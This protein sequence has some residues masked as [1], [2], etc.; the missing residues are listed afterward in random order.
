MSPSPL[1]S[2]FFLLELGYSVGVEDEKMIDIVT[3]KGRYLKNLR[4]I[5]TPEET[6]LVYM[7]D[8]V[9]RVLHKRQSEEKA[10]FVLMGHNECERGVYETFV[11]G[12]IQVEDIA[13]EGTTPLWTNSLWSKIFDEIKRSYEES[14]IVGWAI[15]NM[16]TPVRVTPKLEELHREHF[17]G[18]RELFVMMNPLMEEESVFTYQNG[19]LVKKA[20][21]FIYYDQ[22]V[23]RQAPTIEAKKEPTVEVETVENI[24]RPV[25]QYRQFLLEK[26]TS[27]EKKG[28][29]VA[30]VGILCLMILLMG[31]SIYRDKDKMEKIEASIDAWI[32]P[33]GEKEQEYHKTTENPPEVI[34]VT[35]APQETQDDSSQSK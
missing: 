18:V 32:N 4:Q 11:E 24:E 13:F 34:P 33:G 21:F 25:G 28:W 5:G 20:G 6:D 10:L 8:E 1:Y 31:V 19:G 35:E 3:E 22:G 29:S 14:I 17:G 23:R 12:Y 15:R 30:L 2:S 7:E 26:N 27:E 9:Y 16:T